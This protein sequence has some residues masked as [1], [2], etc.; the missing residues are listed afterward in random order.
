MSNSILEDFENAIAIALNQFKRRLE[1]QELFQVQNDLLKELQ[2]EIANIGFCNSE[3][4]KDLS[5]Q[6]QSFYTQLRESGR[7]YENIVD[8]KVVVDTYSAFEK[9]LFDCYCAI[10]TFFPKFLGAKVE[11]D[12]R[13]LFLDGNME[14]CKRNIIEF[15]VKNLGSDQK[16]EMILHFLCLFSVNYRFNQHPNLITTKS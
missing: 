12:T 4:I 11:I 2:K 7:T 5:E 14:L 1:Q 6:Y 10:Y 16:Q 15:K 9:F 3:G 13:D 8:E